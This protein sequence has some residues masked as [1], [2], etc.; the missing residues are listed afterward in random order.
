MARE[1]REFFGGVTMIFSKIVL[2]VFK[3]CEY[4]KELDYTVNG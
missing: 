2:I 4:N 1:C 3:F